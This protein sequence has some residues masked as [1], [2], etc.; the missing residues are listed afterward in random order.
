MSEIL[1]LS[2]TEVGWFEFPRGT[3]VM[4]EALSK[5]HERI[6]NVV[7]WSFT[8]FVAIL[9]PFY[10]S[11][12]GPTNFLYFCDVALFLTLA[13]VWTEKPIFASMAAVGIVLP[14]VL[15]QVDF[16]GSLVGLPV[17]GMTSYM[18][19]S[20][21]P[22]FAR[23]L[24]FFHFWL[25]ILLLYL[26]YR[27][28]YD[29]RAL[30]SWT[31]LAWGLMLISYFLLPAPGDPR[32]FDNQPYNVNYVFGL[33]EESQTWM[34]PLAWLGLLMLALPCVFFIPA[35]WAMNRLWGSHVGQE[36]NLHSS[37][38]SHLLADSSESA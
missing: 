30:M 12:Y 8:G 24:S 33:G 22:L 31:L 20:G 23:F 10:W 32:S 37:E 3:R 2:A 17:S 7:K 11:S 14:Q 34:P 1:V 9:V 35:H 36:K 25:P 18:F 28:G 13:A 4:P 16:L 38:Q 26:V 19:D 27:L 5:K 15:W 21:I 6:P 29:R